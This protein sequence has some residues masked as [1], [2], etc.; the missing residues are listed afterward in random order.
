M[1]FHYSRYQDNQGKWHEGLLEDIHSIEAGVLE[2]LNQPIIEPRVVQPLKNDYLN[3]KPVPML[4]IDQYQSV[5]PKEVEHDN[6]Q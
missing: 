3:I 5:A 2:Y 4:N 1:Q 6:G